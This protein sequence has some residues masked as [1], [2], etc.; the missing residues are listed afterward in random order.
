MKA[1][2]VDEYVS[3]LEQVK[4]IVRNDPKTVSIIEK[5]Q[6]MIDEYAK[7]HAVEVEPVRHG[8]WVDNSYPLE[9]FPIYKFNCSICNFLTNRVGQFKYCPNCG[10][11]MDLKE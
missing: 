5:I 4:S 7:Q 2:N 10:A 8:Y 6:Y 11:K 1:I 3:D 9:G